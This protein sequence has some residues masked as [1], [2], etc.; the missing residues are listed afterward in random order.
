MQIPDRTYRKSGFIG[1][2]LLALFFFGSVSAQDIHFSEWFRSPSTLN[3]GLT[4]LF[5]GS[6][7]IAGIY[8][9]QWAAV[10]VPYQ[11]VNISADAHDFLRAKGLGVGINMYYDQAGDGNLGTFNVNLSVAYTIKLSSDSVHTITPGMQAGYAKRQLDPNRLTWDNQYSGGVYNPNIGS[12]E[13]FGTGYGFLALNA[14]VVYQARW[15]RRQTLQ[16][17]VAMHNLTKPDNSY[18]DNFSEPLSRRLTVHA[19]YDFRIA[20]KWNLIPGVL[21]RQ[22]LDFFEVLPGL[23]ARYY[24]NDSPARY[25]ALYVGAWTRARDAVYLFAGLDID[26]WQFGMSYDINY[27]SLQ[28]ASNNRGGF[29]F[30]IIYIFPVRL[31]KRKFFKTCPDF[32]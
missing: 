1:A 24:L 6:Y 19:S 31:P 29:E 27:S 22:Q 17:G 13:Q 28:V 9:T 32:I 21:Y 2:V 11:T 3:P 16:V 26:T 12:G 20:K 23:N 18:Y 4:G 14:G 15:N 30:S 5:D 25:R 10:T 8:R 7:R